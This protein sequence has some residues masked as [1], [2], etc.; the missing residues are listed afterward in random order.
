MKDKKVKA[1]LQK[2]LQPEGLMPK[3]KIKLLELSLRIFR[4]EL[5]IF[6]K[7]FKKV[8]GIGAFSTEDN[9]LS[10]R[11]IS[12][13]FK[14]E[15][16][17]FIKIKKLS[18]E[19][20]DKELKDIDFRENYTDQLKVRIKLREFFDSILLAVLLQRIKNLFNSK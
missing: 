4:E 8:A 20:T 19:I 11:Q 15:T 14:N 12:R 10:V 5:K 7:A 13:S 2:A 3:E 16:E 17:T 9:F 1:F 18:E 6:N